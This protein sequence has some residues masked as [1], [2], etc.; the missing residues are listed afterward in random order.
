VDDPPQG[1]QIPAGTRTHFGHDRAM[2]SLLHPHDD[3]LVQA[4]HPDLLVAN[5]EGLGTFRRQVTRFVSRI[6]PLN[7]E[8]DVV[9]A[10]VGKLPRTAAE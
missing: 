7:E 9:D 10:R 3:R 8:I 6:Y 5:T 4:S 1:K 2:A